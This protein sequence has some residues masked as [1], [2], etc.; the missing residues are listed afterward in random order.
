RLC[1][2]Q[3][4]Q[5]AAHAARAATTRRYDRQGDPRTLQA[6]AASSSGRDARGRARALQGAPRGEG[7]M[8]GPDSP[9]RYGLTALQTLA[10]AVACIPAV[11]A[12]TSILP[13]PA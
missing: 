1:A 4:A 7:R 8:I 13:G 3:S 2:A 12:L 6:A 10:I 9:R 5:R 11:C